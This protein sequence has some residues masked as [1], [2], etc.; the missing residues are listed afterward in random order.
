MA[1]KKLYMCMALMKYNFPCDLVSALVEANV[2]SKTQSM[3]INNYLY[4]FYHL[5][6]K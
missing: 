6:L 1:N 4:G 3:G 5:P 2:P